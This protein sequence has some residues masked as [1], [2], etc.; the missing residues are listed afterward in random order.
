MLPRVEAGR[1]TK[2]VPKIKSKDY[3]T[4]FLGEMQSTDK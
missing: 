4:Y 2:N 3:R 1:Q